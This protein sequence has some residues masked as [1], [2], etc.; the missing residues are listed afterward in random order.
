M[1]ELL[2][3][4]HVKFLIRYHVVWNCNF[5]EAI[6]KC[7]VKILKTSFLVYEPQIGSK[8]YCVAEYLYSFQAQICDFFTLLTEIKN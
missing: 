2:H 8:M 6:N 4:C 3:D 7:V 5:R 1:K